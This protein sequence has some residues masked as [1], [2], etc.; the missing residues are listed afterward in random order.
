MSSKSK[1]P[2]RRWNPTAQRN[3]VLLVFL[4]A[5]CAVLRPT[6]EQILA[7]KQEM[8]NLLDSLQ[9]DIHEGDSV[10]VTFDRNRVALFSPEGREL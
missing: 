4:W 7:L 10:N 9:K 8:F 5:V 1:R 3:Q 2:G 6:Q